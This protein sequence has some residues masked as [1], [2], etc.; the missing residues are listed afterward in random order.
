[1]AV[2]APYPAYRSVRFVGLKAAAIRPTFYNRL[3]PAGDVGEFRIQNFRQIAGSEFDI[4]PAFAT[5]D[6]NGVK[7][8]GWGV[9][10][11][12][13]SFFSVPAG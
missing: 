5:G 10:E 8:L 1:M 6:I 12:R 2:L 3:I 13:Q 9:D 11:C 4:Q 7:R